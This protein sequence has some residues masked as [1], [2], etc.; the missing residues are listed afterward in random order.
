MAE[1]GLGEPVVETG[2]VVAY[3]S[4]C[5]MQHGQK[6]KT[7]PRS[8]LT[9]AGFQIR[10]VPEGHLCC[11]SAGIYNLVQPEIAAQLRDRKVRNIESTKPQVIAAGNIGCMTQ[12]GSGTSHPD[13][14]HRR[15]ARLGNRWPPAPSLGRSSGLHT[16]RPG[17][18]TGRLGQLN[19]LS[20]SHK[21]MSLPTATSRSSPL[22][23]NKMGGKRY[24]APSL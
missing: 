20:T 23:L 1:L 10:E 4:A 16:K 2:Q 9:K 22:K 24:V 11:G 19:E 21:D 13:R 14:S 17:A 18:Q 12:I 6:I 15:T 8:L 5:S 3:H 7:P